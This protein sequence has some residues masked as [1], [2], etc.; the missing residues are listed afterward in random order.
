MKT[1]FDYEFWKD[2]LTAANY[3]FIADAFF[4]Q[5][6]DRGNNI[7]ISLSSLAIVG[8]IVSFMFLCI[9]QMIKH[10]KESNS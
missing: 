3:I 6:I 1:W 2:M 8:M 10:K 4:Y 7:I 5:I 9:Y